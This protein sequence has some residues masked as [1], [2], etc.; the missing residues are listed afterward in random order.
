M[1]LSLMAALL[2]MSC[3][4]AQTSAPATPWRMGIT[5]SGGI[6][7]RGNGSWAINSDGKVE[8]TAFGGRSCTFDATAEELT[9]FTNLLAKARRDQ[10]KESYAPEDRCCDRIEY[11]LTIDEAGSQRTVEWIDDPLPMPADLTAIV[12]AMSGVAPSL[13]TEYGEKCR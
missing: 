7:G 8:I 6:T 13:R 9:R 5:T 3:T 2:M 11:I 10:W 1:K 12:N 4:T